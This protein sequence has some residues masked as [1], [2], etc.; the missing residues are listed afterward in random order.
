MKQYSLSAWGL[1]LLTRPFKTGS[2]RRLPVVQG[3]L[4]LTQIF[5]QG[6]LELLDLTKED[7]GLLDD[8]PYLDMD[9]IQ[10]GIATIGYIHPPPPFWKVVH[11]IEDRVQPKNSRDAV[12]DSQ[13]PTQELE[14]TVQDVYEYLEKLPQ[15]PLLYMNASLDASLGIHQQAEE[16]KGDVEGEP[17]AQDLSEEYQLEDCLEEEEV[18]VDEFYGIGE[19]D[20]EEE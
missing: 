20:A 1:V 19:N 6:S 10:D 15:E 8:D 4:T 17:E 7:E 3:S 13:I 18:D 9:M 16:G 11:K 14:L 2:S 12:E 5:H